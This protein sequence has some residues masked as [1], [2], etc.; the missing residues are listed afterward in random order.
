MS[1][2]LEDLYLKEDGALKLREIF[3]VS[4]SGE[5]ASTHSKWRY[6]FWIQSDVSGKK[7]SYALHERS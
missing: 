5:K 7:G 6:I 4:G 2:I 3:I 1:I